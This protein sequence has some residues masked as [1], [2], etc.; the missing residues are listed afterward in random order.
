MAQWGLGKNM[1]FH[2]WYGHKALL[3]PPQNKEFLN[4]I[5]V[6]KNKQMGIPNAYIFYLNTDTAPAQVR[7]LLMFEG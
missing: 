2:L 3:N 4:D 6:I 5:N 7:D 1:S